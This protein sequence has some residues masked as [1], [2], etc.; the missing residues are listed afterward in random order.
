MLAPELMRPPWWPLALVALACEPT[1]AVVPDDPDPPEDWQTLACVERHKLDILLIVEDSPA[2][3]EEQPQVA[4]AARQLLEILE[5]ES[6]S[7]WRLA[8]TNTHVNGPHC[9]E[10]PGDG[11]LRSTSCRARLTGFA[12]DGLC[13]AECPLEGPLAPVPWLESVSGETNLE[14]GTDLGD[15]AACLAIQGLGGCE[16]AAPLAA[17]DLALARALDPVDPAFGF[18]RP[19]AELVVAFI[20]VTSD[21]SVADPAIFDPAGDRRFWSDPTRPTPGACWNAGV[22]CSGAAPEFTACAPESWDMSGQPG[23]SAADAVLLP[24][25]LAVARLA[26]LVNAGSTAGVTVLALGGVPADRPDVDYTTACTPDTTTADGICP[27]CAS[28]HGAGT[29][30]VRLAAL[31]RAFASDDDPRVASICSGDPTRMWAPAVERLRDQVKP[32]CLASCVADSD[33]E[34]AAIEPECDVV[35]QLPGE[36]PLA[37]PRCEHRVT[38]GDPVYSIPAG[39]TVCHAIL[40]DP[41]GR[42][43]TLLDDLSPECTDAGLNAELRLVRSTPPRDGTC[44]SANCRRSA[45]PA[46]DCPAPTD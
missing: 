33:P 45:N 20:G 32:A 6:D 44:I 40:S 18:L 41:D 34:T 37:I 1:E 46:V 12:D 10:R 27:G 28:A 39:H 14:P 38:D 29:P 3:T 16:L 13:L 24:V 15:A 11:V 43:Q 25:D 21:C 22:R 17:M 2:M 42:T 19:D 36:D 5:L 8:V 35:E 4:E 26:A 31:A 30:P 7:D 23:A 9:P